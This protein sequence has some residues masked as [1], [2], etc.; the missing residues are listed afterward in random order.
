M[1]KECKAHYDRISHMGSQQEAFESLTM[2]GVELGRD[3]LELHAEAG[4]EIKLGFFY[5]QAAQLLEPPTASVPLH[6]DVCQVLPLDRNTRFLVL[7]E[8]HES[9]QIPHQLCLLLQ[10]R[11]LAGL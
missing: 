11:K 2:S 6:D 7:M 3:F 5:D 1:V 4:D 10:A 9:H 8:E